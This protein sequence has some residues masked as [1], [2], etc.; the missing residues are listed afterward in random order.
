LHELFG[1]KILLIVTQAFFLYL[2][3]D[4]LHFSD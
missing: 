3:Q 1:W 2:V 4:Y